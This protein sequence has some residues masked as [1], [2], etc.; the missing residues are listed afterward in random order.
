[1]PVLLSQSTTVTDL[2]CP[3]SCPRI[4]PKSCSVSAAGSL[5]VALALTDCAA[6]NSLWCMPAVLRKAAGSA[7]AGLGLEAC[8]GVAVRLAFDRRPAFLPSLRQQALV[9]FALSLAF[10]LGE[11]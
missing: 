4:P 3:R 7:A 11:L 2:K 9:A 6:A 8:T 5:T 1:M 10:T